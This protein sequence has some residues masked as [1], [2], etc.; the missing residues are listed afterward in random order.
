[1]EPAN[2]VKGLAQLAHS[3]TQEAR[4]PNGRGAQRIRGLNRPEAATTTQL[5]PQVRQAAAAPSL[6]NNR[7]LISNQQG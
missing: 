6:S 2:K 5:I 7:G 1:M 3:A 4:D